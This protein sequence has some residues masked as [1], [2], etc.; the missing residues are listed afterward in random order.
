MGDLGRCE[1]ID[2][3]IVTMSPTGQEHGGVEVNFG[4]ALKAFV[5][6]RGLGHVRVGEVGIYTRRNPDRVR[7][8]DALYISNERYAC[9]QRQRGYLDV[10]PEIVVEVLSPD[11]RSSDLRDKIAEYFAI[12]VRLLWIADPERRRIAVHMDGHLVAELGEG[13]SLS[14]DDV[15]PGFEVAVAELFED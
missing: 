1:L 3:R 2:G 10:A 7:G 12:G 4:A 14:G 13:D 6:E 11:D 8:A 5:R 9:R 15:L